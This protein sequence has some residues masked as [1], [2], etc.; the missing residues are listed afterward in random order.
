MSNIDPALLHAYLYGGN[1]L[2]AEMDEAMYAAQAP[3]SMR[4]AYMDTLVNDP[5]GFYYDVGGE[6]VY[7]YQRPDDI[8]QYL[9]LAQTERESASKSALDQAKLDMAQQQLEMDRAEF[10]A[11]FGTPEGNLQTARMLGY[12]PGEVAN[13][14]S[15]NDPNE[16][17]AFAEQ[18]FPPNEYGEVDWRE[19]RGE[20][21]RMIEADEAEVAGMEQERMVGREAG[22]MAFLNPEERAKELYLRNVYGPNLAVGRG[23]KL[24]T[25]ASPEE[26]QGQAYKHMQQVK[27]DE[28]LRGQRASQFEPT[29][30]PKYKRR[31]SERRGGLPVS[32]QEYME[33][34]QGA[35]IKP[36]PKGQKPKN[37]REN[38]QQ[39]MER[40]QGAS[41]YGY[42]RDPFYGR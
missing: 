30:K 27:V 5:L 34:Q 33:T 39:Y 1:V 40:G 32:A 35:P 16:L 10:E 22:R 31:K 38:F 14:M 36:T 2:P 25:G 24:F 13:L 18:V 17:Q 41:L 6:S 12:R 21:A 9:A 15:L 37:E 7:D 19:H 20:I 26:A 11:E 29:Y 8:R 3:Q 42:G 4:P 28:I 23:G